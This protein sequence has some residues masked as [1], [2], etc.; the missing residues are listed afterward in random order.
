MPKVSFSLVEQ[1]SD[2]RSKE[3]SYKFLI[4][5]QGATRI[6]VAAITPRIPDQVQL[7]EAKNPSL[8]AVAVQ[9]EQICADIGEI[10]RTFL[11][12]EVKDF[13]DRVIKANQELAR[14]FMGS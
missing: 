7:V 4:E 1:F 14:E 13:Q 12:V 8:R 5:N 10:I 3:L 2:L 6:N 9:Y 11:I